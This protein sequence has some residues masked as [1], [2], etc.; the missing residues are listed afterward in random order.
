MG[1]RSRKCRDRIDGERGAAVVEFALV[2]P[3][4]LMLLVGII[5][6]GRAYSVMVSLQGASREGARALALG[7]SAGEVEATTR[8]STN[9]SIDTVLQSPCS[10]PGLPARVTVTRQFSFGI[11]FVPQVSRTITAASSMRCGL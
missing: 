2:V 9:I 8:D 11:P 4:L 5:E 1:R 10:T 3:I 6:F 7:K